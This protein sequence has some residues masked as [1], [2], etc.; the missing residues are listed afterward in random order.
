MSQ[1][2]KSPRS[3]VVVRYK[4]F[5]SSGKKEPS[6]KPRLWQ[7][8][9]SPV[10]PGLVASSWLGDLH[11]EDRSKPSPPGSPGL[12]GFPLQQAQPLCLT[13]QVLMEL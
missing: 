11:C 6:L 10:A 7:L 13:Q 3:L 2:V 12:G 5:I 9:L 8:P 4:V 1:C